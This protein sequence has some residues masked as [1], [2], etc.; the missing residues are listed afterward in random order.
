MKLKLKPN[1]FLLNPSSAASMSGTR[2]CTTSRRETAG[3]SRAGSSTSAT[4][5]PPSTSAASASRT[6]ARRITASG[7]ATF[8]VTTTAPTSGGTTRRPRQSPF[9]WRRKRTPPRS[10][11]LF[12][13]TKCRQMCTAKICNQSG[14]QFQ[15]NH[16]RHPDYE[17]QDNG[18][19]PGV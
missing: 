18:A 16:G 6:F 14:T 10:S 1:I 5:A 7:S 8:G 15:G 4:R 9:K 13:C 12:E 17:R 2:L 3:T 19:P 11:G